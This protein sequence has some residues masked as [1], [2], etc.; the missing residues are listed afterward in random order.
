M[1]MMRQC[2]YCGD[3]D[4]YEVNFKCDMCGNK[5]K[6]DIMNNPGGN[7]KSSNANKEK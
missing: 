3:E 1:K 7:Q 2:K 5:E 4:L 6:F